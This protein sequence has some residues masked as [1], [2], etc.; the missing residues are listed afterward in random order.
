M[1]GRKAPDGGKT[2]P[3]DPKA[4]AAEPSVRACDACKHGWPVRQLTLVT[5]D[6]NELLVCQDPLACRLRAQAAGIYG[7][8]A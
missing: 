5:A 6:K 4:T 3:L 2:V 8:V 1:L 7:V